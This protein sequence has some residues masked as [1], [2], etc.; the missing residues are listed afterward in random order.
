MIDHSLKE[1]N[2]L[3]IHV[4]K[5]IA[6]SFVGSKIGLRKISTSIILILPHNKYDFSAITGKKPLFFSTRNKRIS[7]VRFIARFDRFGSSRSNE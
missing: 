3:P 1:G 5:Q 4:L 6:C 7:Y 2:L